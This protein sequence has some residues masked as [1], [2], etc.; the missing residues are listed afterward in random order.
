VR[1]T[2]YGVDCLAQAKHKVRFYRTAIKVNMQLGNYGIAGA[3]LG[4][5]LKYAKANR[6]KLEQEYRECEAH[7]MA[8]TA[9]AL[10]PT[11]VPTIGLATATAYLRRALQCSEALGDPV[12]IGADGAALGLALASVGDYDGAAR[13]V[14]DSLAALGA[15]DV[16]SEGRAAIDRASR[17]CSLALLHF[18]AREFNGASVAPPV[19]LALPALRAVSR[20]L[21]ILRPGR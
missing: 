10:D 1:G 15:P 9:S 2:G 20:E 3:Y 4:M 5:L 16:S 6:Q 17:L 19:R 14:G 13:A 11:P 12:D 8:N 18:R 7:G 21:R